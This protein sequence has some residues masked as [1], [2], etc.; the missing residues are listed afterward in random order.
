MA[1]YADRVLTAEAESAQW[2]DAKSEE[3][4][5]PWDEGTMVSWIGDVDQ[6]H[7]EVIARDGQ[8][9][10]HID[11]YHSEDFGLDVGRDASLPFTPDERNQWFVDTY[12][13]EV[14]ATVNDRIA[15]VQ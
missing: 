12:L 6:P 7:V 8:W 10:F 5:D 14:N 13:P 11:L 9:V 1:T 2:T 4:G 15:E 3:F